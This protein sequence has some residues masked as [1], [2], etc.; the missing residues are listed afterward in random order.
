MNPINKQAEQ[1]AE[2]M[3]ENLNDGNLQRLLDKLDDYDKETLK[4]RLGLA[5]IGGFQ[6]WD[7][8]LIDN[9]VKIQ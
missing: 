5:Y 1:I 4:H 3:L 2:Q 7:M 8:I 9:T 6:K